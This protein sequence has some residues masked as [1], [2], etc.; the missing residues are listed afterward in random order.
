MPCD[1]V[2]QVAVSIEAAD[3]DVL[4]EALEKEFGVPVTRRGDE[5]HF[6]HPDGYR[7]SVVKG[8]VILPA[9]REQDANRVK[10]AYAKR[11]LAKVPGRF[12]WTSRE[13]G[14]THV[15]LVRRF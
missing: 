8:K 2:R 3:I 11:M 5:L 1:E 15:Q 10:R 7:V 14:P 12:G 13:T 4:K 6:V 9:G